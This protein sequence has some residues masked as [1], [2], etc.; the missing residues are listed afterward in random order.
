ME[1]RRALG[2]GLEAL[3]PEAQESSA[4]ILTVE[5]SAGIAQLNIQDITPGR[6]QPR[7]AFKQEKLD[8][9][10]ASIKER[11]VVQPVLVRRV[12]AGYELIA[13]ERRLRAAKSLGMQT[14]P[15]IIKDVDDLNA[16]QMALVENI[17]RE[18]LNPIEE[19]RAYKRLATEFSFTQ[20]QIAQAI[21]RDRTS[22]TNTLRLLQLPDT[23]QQLL[24]DDII[25]AGHAKA[26]LA[27]ADTKKQLR[28]C[29]KI[30]KKKLSVREVEYLVRP[31]ADRRTQPAHTPAAD[32]YARAAEEELEKIFGT[33]VS[34]Q[35]RKKRGKIIID[36]FSLDDLNR[37][38]DM[39]RQHQ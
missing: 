18:D 19:A 13:G 39:I 32:P 15:A 38:I 11:G 8:E 23:V 31:Q 26:L 20:E 33:R 5:S 36:Y 12:G 9:L 14:V 22:I 30:I 34:I 28:I 17:Q 24:A 7:S 4:N 21:G 29:E 1:K 16:M 6:Y 3:I 35:H 25:Q 27:V 2:K 10:M 37:I